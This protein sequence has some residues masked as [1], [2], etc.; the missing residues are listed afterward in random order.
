MDYHFVVLVNDLLKIIRII[1]LTYDKIGLA[2][3]M[4]FF[5]NHFTTQPFKWKL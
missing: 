1:T 2:V 4:G 5:L 3:G